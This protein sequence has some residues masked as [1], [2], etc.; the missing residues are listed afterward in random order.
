VWQ[1]LLPA[2]RYREDDAGLAEA[3][4]AGWSATFPHPLAA[5]GTTTADEQFYSHW[6]RSPFADRYVGQMAAAIVD[7]VQLGR[8]G[9][10]DVLA[11]SFSSPDLMGHGF[12]PNSQEMHDMYVQLD[13]TIGALLDHLDATLGKGQYV[14]GLSADHGVTEIPEQIT[15]GGGDAGRMN[16]PA[17]GG[18]IETAAAA[19]MG[20]GQYVARTNW[21]D[22]YFAPGKYEALKQSPAALQAVIRAIEARPG[23]ARVFRSEELTGDA[24]LSS[25]DPQRRAAALSYVPGRSG[26][27]VMSFKPGWINVGTG[28]THGSANPADQRVPLVFYGYGIKPGTYPTAVTP[29]DLVPTLAAVAGITLPDA[30]GRPLR[31]AIRAGTSS[32]ARGQQ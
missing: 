20:P 32:S 4:P 22:V 29:A 27:L 14:V 2:A 30:S 1:R 12:G 18:A 23:I 16:M 3:P 5:A 10:T 31:P 19:A 9:T 21:S 8:R 17:I 25:S 11:I 6:E 7:A 13:R 26:D 15:A 28:T 24:A